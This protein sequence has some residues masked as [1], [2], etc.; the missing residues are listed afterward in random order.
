MRAKHIALVNW[1][2]LPI[3]TYLLHQVTAITGETGAGKT[4]VLDAIIALM[5]AGMSRIGR[6]NMASE[7]GN[8]HR[9]AAKAYRRIPE[10]VLGAHRA[11]FAR[12]SA[13]SYV[14][15]AWEPEEGEAEASV[16]TSILGVSAL[17]RERQARE[18]NQCLALVVGEAL[19]HATFV[20]EKHGQR[21]IL[22]VESCIDVL[23]ARHGIR[24]G[25]RR[26]GVVSFTNEP[27]RFLQH[28]YGFFRGREELSPEEADRCAMAFCRFI[29][30]EGVEDVSEF[31]RKLIMPDPRSNEDFVGIRKSIRTNRGLARRA[32]ELQDQRKLLGQALQCC[33]DHTTA[34]L[35]ARA[36]EAHE[37]K[38]RKHGLEEEKRI[39]VRQNADAAKLLAL[40]GEQ[41]SAEEARL[42]DALLQVVALTAQ[43]EGFK[44]YTDRKAYQKEIAELKLILRSE[45]SKVEDIQTRI[46]AAAPFLKILELASTG[47]ERLGVLASAVKAAMSVSRVPARFSIDALV[48]VRGL[49]EEPGADRWAEIASLCAP[50]E[51]PLFDL[52]AQLCG[53]DRALL[54][55]LA[56][57]EQDLAKER[58]AV[59][60]RL[61]SLSRERAELEQRGVV[62]PP[63]WAV[64]AMAYVKKNIEEANPVF[65]YELIKEVKNPDWQMAIEGRIGNDRFNLVVD[66]RHERAVNNLLRRFKGQGTL[67]QGKK[68]LEEAQG[69]RPI[70]ESIV[71]DLE[72]DNQIAKAFLVDRFGHIP[73]LADNA[74]I[75][76]VRNGLQ[77]D[78]R[79]AGGLT[80]R[81]VREQGRRLY[82]GSRAVERRRK[83]IAEELKAAGMEAREL[84]NIGALLAQLRGA[85][86]ALLELG[87]ETLGACAERARRALEGIKANEAKILDVDTSE[88][89]ELEKSRDKWTLAEQ[90]AR[91][92][93]ERLTGEIHAQETAVRQRE[94]RLGAISR[95]LPAVDTDLVDALNREVKLQERAYWVSGAQ[96]QAEMAARAANLPA[97]A[98][99]GEAI[100]KQRSPMSQAI[101]SLGL[102]VDRYNTAAGVET[103]ISVTALQSL[104]PEIEAAFGIMADKYREIDTLL[105][106]ISKDGLANANAELE[107]HAGIM[108][109]TF[110]QY[111]C[112]KLLAEIENAEKVLDRLNADLRTYTFGTE[113]YRFAQ[114]AASDEFG[115]RLAFFRYVRDKTKKDDT[116]DPFADGE[117]PPELVLVR[118]EIVRL[119]SSDEEKDVHDLERLADYRNYYLYEMF[120]FFRSADG[121]EKEIAMSKN[122]KDSGG[123][124]ENGILIARAATIASALELDQKG[125]HLRFVAIDEMMKKTD[126][127]RIRESVRFLAKRMRLQVLFVMPTRSIGPFKDLADGEYNVARV[128]T[129]HP[130]G[131]LQDKVVVSAFRYD[132]KAVGDLRDA[133]VEQ[134]RERALAEFDTEE[135]AAAVREV[136]P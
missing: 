29:P 115:R 126:E 13:H 113:R 27:T 31:V 32:R 21:T 133:R 46:A 7:D 117:M 10:Y 25:Q 49:P 2:T 129:A 35:V 50:V 82:F 51:K 33:G 76:Q 119:L 47:G 77:K 55:Y 28:M 94:E 63:D 62:A 74:D 44:R 104:D 111:F 73:K 98:S 110:T 136:Q 22:P 60:A 120:K 122:A 96:V 106:A 23:R 19:D 15:I 102:L 92:A 83:E 112:D 14:A 42:K 56:P 135:T 86:K 8:V 5:S 93:S 17:L 69:K 131:E 123:E 39:L 75:M 114:F 89:D 125:P 43:L 99:L 130:E 18:L 84:E 105:S 91:E 36:L 107:H 66:P 81:N 40:K 132:R 9:K 108:R 124:K 16:F 57:L 87:A 118:D 38:G 3:G 85:D 20:E 67:V 88:F 70:P 80:T 11:F 134:V 90:D 109:K 64:E 97:G 24:K 78:G 95:E 26:T 34:Y 101:T 52:R 65:L 127:E 37:L 79:S 30:Q 100:R 1:G 12:Q 53:E 72:V 4:S 116:F 68:A 128:Y 41:R 71:H 48:M 61:E 45:R 54:T 121:S 103:P 6:L 59:K 58:N